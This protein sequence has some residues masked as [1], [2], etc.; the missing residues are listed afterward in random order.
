MTIAQIQS[1]LTNTLDFIEK[2]RDK[3]VEQERL[4]SRLQEQS[5]ESKVRA[6]KAKAQAEAIKSITEP[7]LEAI[8][9]LIT[10]NARKEST[11][12]FWYGVLTSFPIGILASLTAPTSYNYA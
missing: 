2:L 9:S 11:R 3:A 1:E 6:E 8:T 4:I 7:Q 10:A 5:K 12:G